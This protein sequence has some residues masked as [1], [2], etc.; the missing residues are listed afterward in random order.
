MKRPRKGSPRHVKVTST[1]LDRSQHILIPLPCQDIDSDSDSTSDGQSDSNS[2][3][4]DLVI[5]RGGGRPKLKK[6]PRRVRLVAKLAIDDILANVCL[7]NAYPD[8]PE[9][10]SDF[11]RGALIRSARSLNDKAIVQR[12]K[13]SD[14]YWKPF[15]TFVSCHLTSHAPYSHYCSQYNVCPRCVAR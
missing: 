3:N 6:Q 7:T 1:H 11:G 12:L 8:G 15:A 14:A 13:Q 9:M 2:D 4:I 10:V 5:P